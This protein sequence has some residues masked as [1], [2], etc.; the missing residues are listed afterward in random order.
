MASEIRQAHVIQ[1]RLYE[2]LKNGI[3]KVLTSHGM[4]SVSLTELLIGELS[5]AIYEV[6]DKEYRPVKH[7]KESEEKAQDDRLTAEAIK[8]GGYGG[9]SDFI[10]PT[11]RQ[12]VFLVK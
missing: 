3:D 9:T 10:P 1:E 4:T 12:I 7:L 11:D 2:K 6:I 8:Y 5:L